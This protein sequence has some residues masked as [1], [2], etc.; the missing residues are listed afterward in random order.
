MSPLT[1]YRLGRVG[2]AP[3]L[4][5][6][7]LS[8][9]TATAFRRVFEDWSFLPFLMVLAGSVHLVLALCRLLRIHLLIA[10]PLSLITGVAVIAARMYPG[11][12]RLGFIPGGSTW[13]A[14]IDDITQSWSD[15]NSSAPPVAPA[16]GFLLVAAL[17]L[18][19]VCYTSDT[20]AMRAFGRVEAAIPSAIV[21]TFVSVLGETGNRSNRMWTTTLWLF[22]A[23]VTVA[24]LRDDHGDQTS[25][26][27]GGGRARRVLRTALAAGLLSLAAGGIAYAVAPRLPGATSKALIDQ[28]NSDDATVSVVNP[29]VDLRSRLIGYSN[30]ILF[31]IEADRPAYWHLTSLPDF[32][33]K[34]WK[35]NETFTSANGRLRP[36]PRG[37]SLRQKVTIE[38]MGEG[39]VPAAFEAV[40][41]S[42]K[43]SF[44]YNPE[45]ATVRLA[46]NA[47][48]TPG[49][50]YTV[51]SVI[52]SYS[53]RQLR[54]AGSANP[55]DERYLAL[56]KNFP[57]SLRSLAADVVAGKESTYAQAVTLQ[58][59]FRDNFEYDLDVDYGS[60][61]S[62][63]EDF[64]E[65]RRGF[66]EHFASTFAAMARTLG[67]PSRVAVGFTSG[68]KDS[69][70]YVV[71]ARNAHAWPEVWFD[72]I[73]W[74]SFEPTPG[75]GAPGTEGYTGVQPEQD[76]TVAPDDSD[77][78]ASG[79]DAA[80]T[81][82]AASSATGASGLPGSSIPSGATGTGASG[83]GG[84]PTGP[85]TSS[86]TDSLHQP[87]GSGGGGALLT[88]IIVMTVLVA[89][90]AAWVVGLPRVV[91]ERRL[92]RA[93][94]APSDRVLQSWQ[95]TTVLLGLLG[96]RRR[97]EET[98]LEHA[99]RAA[100]LRPDLS[101]DVERLAD[102]ATRAL[103]AAEAV[104]ASLAEEADAIRRQLAGSLLATAPAR[105]RI[106]R[107]IDP[108]L[109]AA[110]S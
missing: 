92:R 16:G 32:D 90:G 54:A 62:A 64:V 43:S 21:F 80:P 87:S 79:P 61:S 14:A 77:P 45:T 41:I 106:R 67:I 25:V 35:A 109:A 108:R 27:L 2:I 86:P 76:E 29:M 4:S 5:I 23:A 96:T 69:G 88:V 91:R 98:P 26:W 103:Y 52:G 95:D 78:N 83:P 99:T 3:T 36:S 101:S 82:T 102:L 89:L 68:V 84:F 100:Q 24:L 85:G 75:R 105:V 51:T 72:R 48:L 20:F 7:A 42:G 63:M 97:P 57:D 15:F 40:A 34:S 12:V 81:T 73:G 66:C 74:V 65:E 60:S 6:T 33:G 110:V 28:D 44:V 9:V 18:L 93:G 107:Y 55:P 49:L 11:T 39:W 47:D 30:R 59:W 19:L 31:R 46:N 13:R 58:N 71:R 10:T 37:R 104:D 56:P 53:V 38:N 50:T 70:R 22:T 8:V 94:D 17:A 1:T